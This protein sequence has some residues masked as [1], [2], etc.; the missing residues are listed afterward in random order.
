[1]SI[2]YVPPINLLGKGCLKEAKGPIKSLEAKK[3]F[4]VSD[5]FLTS[6][7]TVRKVT[8]MLEEIGVS[9]VI[10]NDV[11]PNPTVNNVNNGLKVL[12]EENCDIVITIGGGS[13]QDCGKA[14]SI[15]ATNGGVTKDYEGVNKTTKKCLP[16]IAITTTAGTSAEVTINYVITDEERHVKM[17]MVDTN[18]LAAITV[19]DPELMI[20]K[21]AAL[22]AATGMDA[23]THAIEAVVAKGAY[24]V[25][26]STSLYAI[27]EIFEFLPR[28]VKD[29]SDIEAREQMCYACFL[30]GIAF[31]NAGL[32]NVHAM[33][34][35]L[36]GLY[37]LPHGVC[38]AM[39]LPYVEEENA[40]AA[41]AKFRPI[42][43]VIGMNIADKS[44]EECVDF[45]I[46]QIKA[47]S[48]EVGIPKS[49]KEVGV[50]NPDL[51]KLAEFAMKDACAGANPVFFDK[52]KL[53]ELFKKIV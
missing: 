8:D 39:L 38:N 50:D 35:Q 48:E 49:L 32:G 3:A 15:L 31:S 33:A 40:K 24:D 46:G 43:E 34:H 11:K 1:M 29:G 6:N 7:G 2:Y 51:D 13:P 44:D 12:K 5:K 10:Y 37:D 41:P 4:V 53:I 36:G 28:A 26:D 21:P 52:Q 14:I 22:T 18:S 17:I 16:I 20:G 30:N 9:Y 19:N 42:A 27:K 45:V 23:L 47:L 25:T